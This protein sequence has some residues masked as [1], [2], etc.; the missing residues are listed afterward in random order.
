M[1]MKNIPEDKKTELLKALQAVV[2]KIEEIEKEAKTPEEHA[3]PAELEA[4]I[5]ELHE[6]AEKHGLT[7]IMAMETFDTDEASG[8]CLS[9]YGTIGKQLKLIISMIQQIAKAVHKPAPDILKDLTK[10]MLLR[11]LL[12]DDE[13][14]T[15]CD[16]PQKSPAGNGRCA[17]L[18]CR[19]SR[20]RSTAL[21]A[22]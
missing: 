9:C 22:S 18:I 5:K 20:Q 1:N 4:A 12:S 10:L 2:G 14:E 16:C 19:R 3:L 15:T 11:E 13:E 7:F 21:C 6:L 8:Q 17:A